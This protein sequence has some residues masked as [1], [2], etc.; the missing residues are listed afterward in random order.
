MQP[1]KPFLVPIEEKIGPLKQIT[2]ITKGYS[3]EQK[4]KLESAMDTYLARIV[5][6][7]DRDAKQQEFQLIAQ[8]YSADVRCNKPI[9]FLHDEPAATVCSLYSF[10]AGDDAE[11]TIGTL[12]EARQYECGVAAGC[13]LLRINQVC[14]TTH[15][16]KARKAQ[17]HERYV[18]RY[19]ALEFR[20]P[21]D[22]ELLRFVELHYDT[23]EAA[24]DQLQHDD[25]HLGNI[26]LQGD[27][28][29]GVIDFNRYDWGDPLHEFVK[30]AWFTWPV[31]PAFAQGQVVGYFGQGQLPDAIWVQLAVY[32]AM[33]LFST[34]VWTLENFPAEWPQLAEQAA[35]ILQEYEYF[36]TVRPAWA[37]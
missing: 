28:Y 22:Q 13:D 34:A 20:Y 23:T 19:H 8:V 31:S 16:W 9:L 17:K 14:G 1:L 12:P 21:N 26:I 15:N 10:L 24:H 11:E 36:T 33:S 18:A 3:N 7:R 5:P 4:F 27:A 32:V 2:P 37:G 35:T 29:G 6:D 25:F 30:L